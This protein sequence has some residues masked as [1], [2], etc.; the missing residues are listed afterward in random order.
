MTNCLHLSG[1]REQP[2]TFNVD[3]IVETKGCENGDG[4]LDSKLQLT[5]KIKKECFFT[6]H[7]DNCTLKPALL[8]H[9][10]SFFPHPY[11]NPGLYVGYV[12]AAVKYRLEYL[13]MML[14]ISFSG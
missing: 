9:L 5:L 11:E 6:L 2:E 13:S 1:H 12:G 3:T 7:L 14:H 4:Q 8:L 10:F